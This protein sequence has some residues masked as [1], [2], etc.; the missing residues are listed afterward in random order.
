MINTKQLLESKWPILDHK[1]DI[2][3]VISKIYSDQ[4][5]SHCKVIYLQAIKGEQKQQ[6]TEDYF[7]KLV[8]LNQ[9]QIL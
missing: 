4:R 7:N 3:Y 6:F 9:L 1:T 2:I 5:Q 8:N